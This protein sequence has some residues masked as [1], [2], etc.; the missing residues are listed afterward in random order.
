MGVWPAARTS[1]GRRPVCDSLRVWSSVSCCGRPGVITLSVGAV[2]LT[3]IGLRLTGCFSVAGEW[4]V[5]A[6][7]TSRREQSRAG[8]PERRGKT[9]RH[10][11]SGSVG[12]GPA[13]G[14]RRRQFRERIREVAESS[15]RAAIGQW[16]VPAADRW[17]STWPQRL[18]GRRRFRGR[19]LTAASPADTHDM[20]TRATHTQ[21]PAAPD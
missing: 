5:E 8:A 6:G 11:V 1:G 17:P 2:R 14:R 13:R 10:T 4:P 18:T 7:E 3:I 12:A 20:P 16:G 15:G 9:S 21:L 19:G